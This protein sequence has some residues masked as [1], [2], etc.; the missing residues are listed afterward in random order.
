MGTVLASPTGCVQPLV[1]ELQKVLLEL[2]SSCT[3]LIDMKKL[4]TVLELASRHIAELQPKVDETKKKVADLS[5]A[6]AANAVSSTFKAL[7]ESGASPCMQTIDASYASWVEYEQHYADYGSNMKECVVLMKLHIWE[8]LREFLQRASIVQMEECHALG[9]LYMKLQ[10][11]CQHE[12]SMLAAACQAFIPCTVLLP[13]KT[14]QVRF[15]VK[16]GVSF[17]ESPLH[18][19][20]TQLAASSIKPFLWHSESSEHCLTNFVI[21]LRRQAVPQADLT[22][23]LADARLR[24]VKAALTVKAMLGRALQPEHQQVL[25]KEP[26]KVEQLQCACAN[27]WREENTAATEG[28]SQEDCHKFQ[29]WKEGDYLDGVKAKFEDTLEQINKGIFNIIKAQVNT[30]VNSIKPY[31][32]GGS[33]AT[34]SWQHHLPEDVTYNLLVPKVRSIQAGP[35]IPAYNKLKQDR[36]VAPLWP[37]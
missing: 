12:S 22:L 16:V 6:E 29:E 21:D 35:L 10:Q 24:Y 4:L 31:A 5:A 13:S 32:K 17:L 3:S 27:L 23:E 8:T 28:L 7:T 34:E 11:A 19:S 18:P 33:A 36:S 2:C 25:L 30:C 37:S 1:Q 26:S 15:V 14:K 9:E 20:N